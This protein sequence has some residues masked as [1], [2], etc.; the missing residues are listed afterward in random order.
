MEQ[1]TTYIIA[2]INSWTW[3]AVLKKKKNGN[4]DKR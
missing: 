1:E 4:G 3:S 2:T